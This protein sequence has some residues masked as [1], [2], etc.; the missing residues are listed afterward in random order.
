ML[1]AH[2]GWTSSTTYQRSS[3]CR[4]VEAV[5]AAGVCRHR[6][7]LQLARRLLHL[8]CGQLSQRGSSGG[9]QPACEQSGV[10]LCAA[11]SR[12]SR[13]RCSAQVL[14]LERTGTFMRC[15]RYQATLRCRQAGC[16]GVWLT[17]EGPPLLHLAQQLCQQH[18]SP[19]LVVELG[20]QHKSQHQSQCWSLY[21]H[22]QMYNN[23][24]SACK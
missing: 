16:R 3:C 6:R 8:L 7:L 22:V 1:G 17:C 21:S 11:G 12:G 10:A 23:G 18:S 2:A 13:A 20:L 5:A 9:L 14:E 4:L 19:A 15:H 24:L